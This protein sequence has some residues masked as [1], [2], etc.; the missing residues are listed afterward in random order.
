MALL[1]MEFISENNIS[2]ELVNS[3]DEE[4]HVE[5]AKKIEEYN[6]YVTI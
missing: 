2:E 1:N 6:Y 5:L 4:L 3:F